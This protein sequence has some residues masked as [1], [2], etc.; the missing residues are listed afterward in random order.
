MVLPATVDD[1]DPF[2]S[3]GSK[4]GMMPHTSGFL[5]FVE[6]TGPGA[7]SN[8]LPRILMEGLF[9]KPGASQ[10]TVDP[11]GFAAPLGDRC[12][13]RAFGNLLGAAKPTSVGT[14][15]G[16]QTRLQRRTRP[17]KT[18][19]EF[20]VRLFLVDRF[21][22]FVKASDG[23]NQGPQLRD[24]RLHHEDRRFDD[25]LVRG[26]RKCRTDLLKAMIDRLVAA[27]PVISVEPAHSFV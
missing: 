3:E 5:A 27:T 12:N 14:H 4:R 2:V 9:D 6:S 24:D 19:E 7:V 13:A 20:H 1:S 15:D 10:P 23:L 22:S 8:R 17:W 16:Q 11:F 26:Q 25:R 21:D 18:T